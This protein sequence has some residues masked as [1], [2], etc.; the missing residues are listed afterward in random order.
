MNELLKYGA[1]ALGGYVL[2]NWLKNASF[3]QPAYIPAMPI[4]A[5]VNPNTVT[6]A[7][8]DTRSTLR[9]KM[10]TAVNSTDG[11][12]TSNYE[13]WANVYHTITG[14]FAPAY[15][16]SNMGRNGIA[17]DRPITVDQFLDAARLGGL[18]GV[19]GMGFLIAPNYFERNLVRN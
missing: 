4:S 6:S 15:P 10:L 7:I 16:D 1:Y 11:N 19:S 2:Y 9:T 14:S 8:T 12:G 5:N 3:M 17:G 18:G 13:G